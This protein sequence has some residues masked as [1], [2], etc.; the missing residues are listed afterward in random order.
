MEDEDFS[1]YS[2]HTESLVQEKEAE[3]QAAIQEKEAAIQEKE[4][5]KVT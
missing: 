1:R 3:K 5:E 2:M 4:A